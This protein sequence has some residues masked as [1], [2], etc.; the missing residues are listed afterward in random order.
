MERKLGEQALDAPTYSKEHARC[1]GSETQGSLASCNLNIATRLLADVCTADFLQ[2]LSVKLI[3][4]NVS[5]SATDK[6]ANHILSG[7]YLR[8]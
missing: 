8:V 6:I 7:R 4:H 5:H 2:P 3:T 1:P